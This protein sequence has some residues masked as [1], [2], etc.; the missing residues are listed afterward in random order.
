MGEHIETQETVTN[1]KAISFNL[2]AYAQGLYLC[3]IINQSGE[4]LETKKVF[5][6]HD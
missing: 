2:Q 3:K 4:V 1:S 6:S 5:I